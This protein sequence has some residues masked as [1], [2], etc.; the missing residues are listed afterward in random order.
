LK[1]Y[2][3]FFNSNINIT[4]YKEVFGCLGIGFY[5]VRWFVF[6][7]FLSPL[8]WADCNFLIC[9]LFSTIVSVSNVPRREVHILFGHQKQ[10]SPPLGSSLSWAFKCS[11]T[12]PKYLFKWIQHSFKCWIYLFLNPFWVFKQWFMKF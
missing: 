1:F 8:I 9:N 5:S 11:I 6:F 12:L 7:N 10:T 4:T 2:K 3:S